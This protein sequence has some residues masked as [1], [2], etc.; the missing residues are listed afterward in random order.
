MSQTITDTAAVEAYVHEGEQKAME[1]G[2]R[3]PI[4]FN[5]EGTLH[6]EILDAYNRCGFYVFENV[7]GEDELDDLRTDFEHMLER[8]PRTKC[9]TVDAQGR[10]AIGIDDK[11]SSFNFAKPLGDPMG[12]HGRHHA[13]MTELEPPSESP[14][15]VIVKIA[16]PL[17]L[18]DAYLRLYGHPQLLSVAEQINGVDFTP[19][20]ES[21]VVKQPGLG[22]S[23]AWHQDGTQ[24]WDAPDWDQDTHGF[25]FM[26]QLFPTNVANGLWVVPGTHKQ[27]QL[28]IRK[29]VEETGS[30]RLPD[31]VPMVCN[32]G[33]VGIANRQ[34][35]HGSFPNTS[36]SRRVSLIFGFHR[37]SSVQGV[38]IE[39]ADKEVVY[40]DEYI[41]ARSRIISLAI[42]ARRQRF[43]GEAPFVYQPML[44]Q[45]DD[46]RWN[47]TTRESL[48]KNY[49][50][51]NLSI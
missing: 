46:N 27:G 6:Q 4:R 3:G 18:M 8:A 2:N 30:D 47:E 10:P 38:R 11:R 25:N 41:Q 44:G 28:D 31:A 14:E 45:E 12:G 50:Q 15:Y 42:D 26:A 37:R 48:L 40:D 51:F 23:I 16:N 20:S 13:R 5:A 7:L 34:S 35:L 49:P 22:A 43:P 39:R 1:L 32:P 36:T 33:D 21:I 9:A 17:R 24:R 29:M 19:F